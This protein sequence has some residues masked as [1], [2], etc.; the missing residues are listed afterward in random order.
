MSPALSTTSGLGVLVNNSRGITYA[1]ERPAYHARFGENWQRAIEQAVH[2]MIADL[3]ANTKAG[4]LKTSASG[5][6]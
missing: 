5:T 4:R 6:L 1:Y 2:D 3:A